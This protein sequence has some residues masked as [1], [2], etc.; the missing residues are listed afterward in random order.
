LS[1]SSKSPEEY[2]LL[3]QRDEEQILSEIKGNI[4]TE[5]FYSFPLDGRMVTGISWVGTK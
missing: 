1:I 5:M 3:D 4:I 2:E